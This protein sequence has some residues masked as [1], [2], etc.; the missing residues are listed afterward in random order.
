MIFLAEATG[1]ADLGGAVA[2]MALLQLTR[3]ELVFFCSGVGTKFL[4]QFGEQFV[5]RTGTFPFCCS[6]RTFFR[7]I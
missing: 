1:V 2:A 6:F 7:R 4:R 3:A 5:H